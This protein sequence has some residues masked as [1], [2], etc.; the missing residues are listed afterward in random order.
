ML[1]M[2]LEN[3]SFSNEER[4][5]LCFH[6]NYS[7]TENLTNNWNIPSSDSSENSFWGQRKEIVKIRD[8]FELFEKG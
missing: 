2:I 3:S 1:F 6:D 4:C 8:L 5:R 7:L